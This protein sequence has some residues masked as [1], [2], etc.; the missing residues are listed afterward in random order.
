M[1]KEVKVKEAI[2]VTLI[3]AEAGKT[4]EVSGINTGDDEMR[5]FLFRL[6]CYEGEPI[7]LISKKRKGCVAVIK[8]G[9][10]SFDNQLAEAVSLRNIAQ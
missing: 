1:F 4:Y 7:T 8:D 5:S 9:R 3:E 2:M 6:G 10:Y